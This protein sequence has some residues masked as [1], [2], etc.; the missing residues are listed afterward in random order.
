MRINNVKLLIIFK[1]CDI[2]RKNIKNG[3]TNEIILNDTK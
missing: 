1:I 3:K 2:I